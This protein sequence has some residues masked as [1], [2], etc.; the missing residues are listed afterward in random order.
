M[1]KLPA[2]LRS[3][4]FANTRP[5]RRLRMA[6]VGANVALAA[7]VGAGI[8]LHQPNLG[9][10]LPSRPAA[11]VAASRRPAP[12]VA[13]PAVEPTKPT[14]GDTAAVSNTA[15]GY[16]QATTTTAAPVRTKPD[17]AQLNEVKREIDDR[18]RGF[19]PT[20]HQ[21]SEFGLQVCDAFGE[22]YSYAEIKAGVLKAA[23]R[24]PIGVSEGDAAYA[25]QSAVHLY[26][27]AY[28]ASLTS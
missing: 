26:C 21:V 24:A 6:A 16:A 27:P 18:T 8:V 13:G 28:N 11:I 5:N 23:Q 2:V 12:V 15:P 22:G 3:T 4:A 14:P 1:H 25:V 20:D 9:E 19:T 7:L 17:R 10:V